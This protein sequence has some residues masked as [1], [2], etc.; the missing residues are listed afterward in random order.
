M[1]ES[2]KQKK[3]VIFDMDG[4]LVDS[5]P[6]YQRMFRQFLEENNCN[7]R[8]DIFC[9]I[10]GASSTGTWEIMTQLWYEP[11]DGE[12]LH[13]EFRRQ[14]PDFKVPYQEALFPGIKELLQWLTE[15]N[16]KLALASSS[17]EKNIG[18]MLEETGLKSYF[19]VIVSGNMF[20]ESK[21]NP[22]IYEYTWSLLGLDKSECLVVE[23]SEYGIQAG[24]AAG[25]EV[26]AITDRRFG[27]DQ[28]SSNY[29]IDQTCKLKD[30]LKKME[31]R[32]NK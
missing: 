18:R 13:R 27:Y 23:D 7:I 5:E 2:N 6:I 31:K 21:P 29:M 11:I 15:N 20:R 25:L 32:K 28:S 24:R 30:L 22:E 8:E 3:A 17:S 12:A 16:Y 4:V 10:A 9:R 1:V 19:S 26:V 14:Y